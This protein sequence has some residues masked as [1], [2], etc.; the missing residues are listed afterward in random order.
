[1]RNSKK[2]YKHIDLKIK[3]NILIF[4]VLFMLMIEDNIIQNEMIE[5]SYR[6]QNTSRDIEGLT[7]SLVDQLSTSKFY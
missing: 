1:M 3:F 6:S 7:Q 2:F 5:S 4:N